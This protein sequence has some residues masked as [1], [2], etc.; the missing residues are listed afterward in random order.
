M[1]KRVI[2]SFLILSILFVFLGLFF[3]NSPSQI[4][5]MGMHN[6]LQESIITYEVSFES[7]HSKHPSIPDKNLDE[8]L[9]NCVHMLMKF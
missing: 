7:L 5:N 1:T 4:Q 3:T 2:K 8:K 9:K 6:T